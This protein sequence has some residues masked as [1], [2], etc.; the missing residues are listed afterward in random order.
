MGKVNY[1][2]VEIN[3]SYDSGNVGFYYRV[4]FR[5]LVWWYLKLGF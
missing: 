2:D 5:V 4:I 1:V 3:K